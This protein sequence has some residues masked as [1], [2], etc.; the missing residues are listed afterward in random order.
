MNALPLPQTGFTLIEVLVLVA[1]I[2]LITAV[3][4]ATLP[5]FNSNPA[6]TQLPERLATQLE[7]AH[8]QA[9][10]ERADV[11]LTG[12][13][14]LLLIDGPAGREQINFD[15]AQIVGRLTISAA[16]S[17]LGNLVLTAPGISCTRLSLN[18]AGIS[19]R[20]EC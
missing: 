6:N 7:A 17:S 5:R 10:A 15:N 20:E 16:G 11:A 12:Q 3:V 14:A 13:G 1:L 18:D 2:A 4:A 9:Y 19:V 8:T